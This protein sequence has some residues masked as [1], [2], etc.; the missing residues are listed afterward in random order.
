MWTSIYL[1]NFG[2]TALYILINLKRFI[3]NHVCGRGWL[4]IHLTPAPANT[5][6]AVIT[7]ANR[8]PENVYTNY[9]DDYVAEWV[10]V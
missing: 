8:K 2:P 5:N 1:P 4:V 9:L 10:Q 7:P 6:P 3:T